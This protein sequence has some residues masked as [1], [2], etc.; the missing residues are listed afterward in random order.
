MGLVC[1]QMAMD[2]DFLQGSRVRRYVL[3]AYVVQT[4]SK[5]KFTSDL[6]NFYLVLKTKKQTNNL[7][8]NQTTH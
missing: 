5:W 6:N 4:W 3:F 2:V 7:Y 8:R 1:I